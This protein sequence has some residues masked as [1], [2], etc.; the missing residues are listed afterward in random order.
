VDSKLPNSDS[1]FAE[2]NRRILLID[3]NVAIHDDYRKILVGRANSSELDE[4]GAA[5]FDCSPTEEKLLN[6]DVSSAY[7]GQDGL[8]LVVQALEMGKPFAMAFV[9]MRM[10]PGWDGVETI[11]RIWE[12]DPNLQIVICSAYSD[13]SW[14]RCRP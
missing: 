4:L 5:L 9:D 13:H 11:K 6:F 12:V 10:P 7:Q 14:T 8:S 3:D 1:P 2:E